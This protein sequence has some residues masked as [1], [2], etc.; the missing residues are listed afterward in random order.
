MRLKMHRSAVLLLWTFLLAISA[1]SHAGPASAAQP[2]GQSGVVALLGDARILEED[3]EEWWR[4]QDASTYH[5]VRRDTYDSQRRALDALIAERLLSAEAVRRG[6][7]VE[8]LLAGEIASGTKAVTDADVREFVASNPMPPGTTTAMVAP[9]V[10]ALLAQR[11]RESAKEEYLR[12]LRLAPEA[13][14]RVFLE[15]PRVSITRAA[16]SPTLGG[17]AA[18]VE[19]VVF[20]DFECPFCRRAEPVLARL[21]E[22]FP[23]E[24]RFVW[25]HFPLSTHQSARSA[26]EAAQCAHDQGEFWSFH[27]ALFA[28]S[29]LLRPAGFAAIADRLGLD[30][31]VF[32]ACVNAHSHAA[33]VADDTATGERV[34]VSGTPTVFINGVA[35]VGALSYEVYERAVLEEVARLSGRTGPTDQ[36]SEPESPR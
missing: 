15:P 29:A 20:S 36:A 17:A 14:V 6:L 4:R 28:D 10:A 21:R 1:R 18:R 23:T 24:I 9:L 35:F 22:R 31:G 25:R 26:A 3:L 30:T 19:V 27:D 33:D 5:R 7:T 34:G 13:R 32:A 11:A 16:H 2:P 12:R 8:E